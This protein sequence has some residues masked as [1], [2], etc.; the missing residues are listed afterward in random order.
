M[1]HPAFA[2]HFPD[3]PIVP[4]VV[5]LDTALQAIALAEN[6]PLDQYELSSVK[7]LSP[8]SPADSENSKKDHLNMLLD[9]KQTSEQRIQFDIACGERKIVTATVNLGSNKVAT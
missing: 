4:G 1:Q 8:L 5:L 6:L 2:G 3:A 7:F 9:Y